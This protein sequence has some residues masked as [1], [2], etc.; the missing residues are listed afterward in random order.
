MLIIS[1]D[2]T[3]LLDSNIHLLLVKSQYVNTAWFRPDLVHSTAC[4]KPWSIL[5]AGIFD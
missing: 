3:T 1:N 2:Q 4:F 5:N